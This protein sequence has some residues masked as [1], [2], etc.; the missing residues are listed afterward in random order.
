MTGLSVPDVYT[1]ADGP[2][3]P[4]IDSKKRSSERFLLDALLVRGSRISGI[5]HR[6]ERD[7]DQKPVDLGILD[8]AAL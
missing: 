3:G 1:V 6:T 2:K 4:L 7:T 5:E 8:L